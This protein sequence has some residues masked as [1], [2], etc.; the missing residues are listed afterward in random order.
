MTTYSAGTVVTVRMRFADQ[1]GSKPRP[2][3]I[4]SS[5][6]YHGTRADAV[7][8]AL[9]GQVGGRNRTGD[10]EIS[11]WQH[12]GLLSP[13][14]AKGVIATIAR[15]AIRQDLGSLTQPDFDRV[16]GGVRAI[17]GL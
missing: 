9:T 2:A 10:C 16:K 14:K 15:S 8:M 13:T 4:I 3:V 17:F 1:S 5:D 11:D 6:R 12:A 7:V